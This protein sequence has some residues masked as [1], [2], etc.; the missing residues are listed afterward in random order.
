MD[1]LDPPDELRPGMTSEVTIEAEA[2]QDVLQVPLQAVLEKDNGFYCLVGVDARDLEVRPVQLG[3]ANE[4]F[5]VIEKGLTAG[6]SVAVNPRQFE[7]IVKFPPYPNGYRA[8][9][10]KTPADKKT[11]PVEVKSEV[12]RVTRLDKDEGSGS[13]SQ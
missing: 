6:L 12:K 9:N 4:Q 2:L 13:K 5:V 3:S 8:R 11:K 10:L 7:E 1:I